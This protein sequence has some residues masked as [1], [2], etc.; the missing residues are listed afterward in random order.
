[1][2]EEN[3]P[4]E[5]KQIF[6]VNSDLEICP[7]GVIKKIEKRKKEKQ[8]LYFDD[9]NTKE[10]WSGSPIITKSGNLVIGIHKGYE[11]INKQINK[12]YNVGVFLKYIINDIVKK[13]ETLNQADKKL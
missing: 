2:I 5:E 7:G 13:S 10:G 1:M 3:Y 12:K 9:C 6:I 8:F 4:L 11:C